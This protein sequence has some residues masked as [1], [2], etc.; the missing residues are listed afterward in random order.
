MMFYFWM[1]SDKLALFCSPELLILIDPSSQDDSFPLN[2]CYSDIVYLY[3]HQVYMV[4]VIQ[5]YDSC[6]LSYCPSILPI[7][8]KIN[9]KCIHAYS[10]QINIDIACPTIVSIT[11]VAKC[12][13]QLA[14]DG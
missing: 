12:K 4:Y 6:S 8:A 14:T 1:L 7:N 10:V 3:L 2:P 9:V 11:N 5:K 13:H